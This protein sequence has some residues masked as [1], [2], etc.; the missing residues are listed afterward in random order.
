MS[1]QKRVIRKQ[2]DADIVHYH[3]MAGGQQFLVLRH[4]H[5]WHPPTDV[6]EDDGRLYV[7]I[8]I[9]GM[10]K[11]E[12]HVTLDDRHLTVSGVREPE[13][14]TCSAYHQLEVRF[15]EFRTDVVLPWAVQEDAIEATYSDGFLRVELPRARSHKVHV[16]DV[17]KTDVSDEVVQ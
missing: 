13:G 8:E 14:R 5:V 16:V 3:V 11:G 12:F 17:A 10:Q 1:A 6:M 9:A 15:G 2:E 4:S 7:L